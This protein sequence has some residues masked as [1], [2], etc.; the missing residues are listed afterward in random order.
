MKLAIIDK[1]RLHY[2]GA[3]LSKQGLGVSESAVILIAKELQQTGFDAE[4]T[5]A[6]QLA[7]NPT[8]DVEAAFDAAYNAQVSSNC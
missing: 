8:I 2:D 7:N 6:L 5:V 3:T 4:K 1:L